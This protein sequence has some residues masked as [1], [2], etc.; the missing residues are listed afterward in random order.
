VTHNRNKVTT[1]FVQV[2]RRQS[3][4]MSQMTAMGNPAQDTQTNIYIWATN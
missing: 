3:S 1:G 4:K 2:K